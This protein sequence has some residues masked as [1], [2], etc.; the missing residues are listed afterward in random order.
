MR[1]QAGRATGRTLRVRA[2]VVALLMAVVMS[3]CSGGDAGGGTQSVD[4]VISVELGGTIATG[5]VNQSQ[6]TGVTIDVGLDSGTE[7]G[8]LVT[9]TLTDP[10]GA[11]QILTGTISTPGAGTLPVGPFDLSGF[12]DGTITVSISVTTPNGTTLESP[13]TSTFALD[14]TP[15]QSPTSVALATDPNPTWPTPTNTINLFNVTQSV[16]LAD[17]GTTPQPGDTVSFVF[18][19]MFGM[20]VQGPAFQTPLGGGLTNWPFDLSTLADGPVSVTLLLEDPAGNQ[21]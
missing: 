2:L 8:T 21:T 3:A 13:L 15:P 10:T 5:V 19:D 7:A 6:S 4:P 20:T 18:T 9:V 12:E 16:I 11:T 14:Q 1:I 17:F